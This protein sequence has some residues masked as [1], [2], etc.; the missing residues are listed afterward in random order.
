MPTPSQPETAATDRECGGCTLH[1]ALTAPD[2]LERRGFLRAAAAALASV[3]L[4]GLGPRT[5]EAMPV[6]TT[7]ARTARRGDR[8]EERRYAVPAA[9]GVLIDKDNSVIVAR[10][11]GKVYAFSLACPHQNTAL[12]WDAADHQFMCPKHKSH[13]QADG[14]FIEGRATRDMDRLALRREGAEL[15]VDIDKI[16]QQDDHPAEWHAAFAAA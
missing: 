13:Y 7:T 4:L 16:Y 3:G 1:D 5:A 11:S 14:T 15:I 8:P 12:R 10:A 9:D 2:A 6:V